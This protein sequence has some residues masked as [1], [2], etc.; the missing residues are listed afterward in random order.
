MKRLLLFALLLLASNAEAQ[1]YIDTYLYTSTY[2]SS[3]SSTS[4]TL[5]LIEDTNTQGHLWWYLPGIGTSNA[6]LTTNGGYPSAV[7]SWRSASSLLGN[8]VIFNQT[9]AQSSANFNITSSLSNSGGY[10]ENT[11]T[12]NDAVALA[13]KAHTTNAHANY[14]LTF[15]IGGG[16]SN[17]DIDGTGGTWSVT[18]AGD[19]TFNSL[20]I[21]TPL[22]GYIRAGYT[23]QTGVGYYVAAGAPSKTADFTEATIANDATSS[24][25][26]VT[27]T[28][29]A[30]LSTGSWSGTGSLNEGINLTVTGPGVNKDIVGTSA[31][32]YVN[33]DGSAFFNGAIVAASVSA[34]NVGTMYGGGGGTSGVPL[35]GTGAF[36]PNGRHTFA[37]GGITID[38]QVVVTHACTVKRLYVILD[39]PPGIGNIVSL[40]IY[41]NG[42]ASTVTVAIT[43]GVTVI[44]SDL[45]N[46]FSCSAGDYLSLLM[47]TVGTPATTVL[48]WG[49]EAD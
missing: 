10:I 36:N 20:S 49:F 18:S 27:K 30:I 8:S 25:G 11:Y 16:T 29:L 38:D 2:A 37:A 23:A 31:N 15:D 47:S 14:G 1:D 46:S 39:I 3:G 5:T 17:I 28:A 19:A 48:A 44:G 42:A 34:P 22:A 12:A 32:W 41:H 35:I 33:S 45:V 7:L 43:G 26:F 24:S 21:G 6:V 40:F 4:N 13:L 9:S